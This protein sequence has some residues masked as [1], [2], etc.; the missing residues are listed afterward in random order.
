[1]F[2]TERERERERERK[3]EK[4]THTNRNIV[5]T[6]E[7]V[8]ERDTQTEIGRTKESICVSVFGCVGNRN[9]VRQTERCLYQPGT[10]IQTDAD[11]HRQK[12]FM[13]KRVSVRV[14]V[15]VCDIK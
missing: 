14:N 3:S 12:P 1:M 9:K 6:K 15:C 7:T 5:R 8:K 10:D 2:F 4:E 11:I 13:P